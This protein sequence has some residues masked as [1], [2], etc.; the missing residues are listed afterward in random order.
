MFG[1]G[2]AGR[3]TGQ[4]SE[5]AHAVTDDAFQHH[6]IVRQVDSVEQVGERLELRQVGVDHWADENEGGH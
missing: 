2:L 5:A 4:A 3:R 1:I 6:R